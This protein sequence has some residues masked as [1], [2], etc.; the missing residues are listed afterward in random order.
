MWGWRVLSPEEPFTQGRPYSDPE[1]NKYLILMTAGRTTIRPPPTTTNRS[2]TPLALPRTAGSGATATSTAL[3]GQMT[4]K[5]RAACEKPRPPAS[6]ST[7]SPSGSKT[8][9]TRA[10]AGGLRLE[11]GGSLRGEQRSRPGAGLRGDCARN[12]EIA[13]RQLRPGKDIPFSGAARLCTSSWDVSQMREP[14]RGAGDGPHPDAA[15]RRT[16]GHR[17]GEGAFCRCRAGRPQR[18]ANRRAQARAQSWAEAVDRLGTS[19]EG[20]RRR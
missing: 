18:A 1:N 4:N 8:M 5:T 9:P 6:P 15:T 12:R 16:R 17:R 20:A 14:P 7:P 11:C 10:P 19:V 2:T 3:I 13:N